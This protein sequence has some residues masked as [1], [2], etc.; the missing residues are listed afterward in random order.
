MWPR[1]PFSDVLETSLPQSLYCHNYFKN[2]Q[3][4]YQSSFSE[5]ILDDFI[6]TWRMYH[7]FTSF[8]PNL[9]WKEKNIY[10]ERKIA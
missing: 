6:W 4:K 1:E 7:S 5:F 10:I 2:L 3:F 8:E 9:E